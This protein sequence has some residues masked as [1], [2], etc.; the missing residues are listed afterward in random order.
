VKRT[1]T[2]RAEAAGETHTEPQA[3]DKRELDVLDVLESAPAG[4]TLAQVAGATGLSPV[5]A[6]RLLVGLADAD[7][8]YARGGRWYA[9]DVSIDRKDQADG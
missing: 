2:S 8:A 5:D 7:V 6:E 1:L 9:D 3:F 4:R